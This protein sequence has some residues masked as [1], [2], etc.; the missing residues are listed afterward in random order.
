[1][2]IR[3]NGGLPRTPWRVLGY[4]LRTSGLVSCR[5]LIWW[6]HTRVWSCARKNS[7]RFNTG[8]HLWRKWMCEGWEMCS[9][10]VVEVDTL[11]LPTPPGTL[12]W[13]PPQDRPHRHKAW[14]FRKLFPMGL[15]SN[16]D[17]RV[18]EDRVC[19]RIHLKIK[20]NGL[21]EIWRG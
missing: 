14:K 4:R 16:A 6:S 20:C 19:T 11:T 2:W 7:T 9:A 18:I 5:E 21:Y 12:T 1:M 13:V 3:L 17:C 10:G 8:W 15:P